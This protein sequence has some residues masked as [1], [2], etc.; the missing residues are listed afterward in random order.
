MTARAQ[1]LLTRVDQLP[2]TPAGV[3]PDPRQT[4]AALALDGC[5]LG[6]YAEVYTLDGDWW[7]RA[8][9]AVADYA[10]VPVPRQ[11]SE[12]LDLELEA[13]P[14]RDATPLTDAVLRLVRAGGVGALTL[15]AIARESG[16]EP[17]WVLSMHGSVQELVDTLVAQIAEDA[18]DEMLPAHEEPSVPDLLVAYTTSERIVAMIRFLALTGVE[19]PA[20]AAEATRDASPVAR[21]DADLADRALVAALALDAWA[22]GA[23]ARRYP[24]PEGL[25]PEVVTELRSLAG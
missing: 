21:D 8:V 22:L 3:D 10:G 1:A 17:E 9:T 25:T 2:V 19:I 18:F 14:F 12:N 7:E 15:E 5:L 11:R 13:S 24:W 16:R 6:T 4:V 23:A 20:E